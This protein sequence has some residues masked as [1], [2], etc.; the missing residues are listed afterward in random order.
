MH[1]YIDFPKLKREYYESMLKIIGSLSRLF[2]ESDVPYL[3]SR[4]AENLY[5]KSFGAKNKG[6]EDSSVDAVYNKAGIG[7][8]TFMGNGA[9]KIAEFNRDILQFASLRALEKAKKIAELRN[10]RIEF[11]KRAYGLN[12][13]QYHCIRREKGKMILCE[14]SMDLIDTAQ[15]KILQDT[16]KSLKFK[17]NK[18]SYIFNV[19]KSVLLKKFPKENIVAEFGVEI[20]EDPFKILGKT[21]EMHKKEVLETMKIK[22]QFVILP[23]YSM[24]K[25]EKIV[26]E[27]SGLNQWN[28]GGRKRDE[29]EVYIRVPHWIHEKFPG[30]FPKRDT[31]FKLRLPNGEFISAKICQDDDKALM[32]DPNKALGQW[33]L[34]DVLELKKGQLLN[35]KMLQEIGI[36]SVIIQKIGELEYSI[37]FREEGEFEDFEEEMS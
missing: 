21:L 17:D 5:C 36:D 3:D 12:E 32:S 8:K 10:K 6:R 25:D 34:R 14:S 33:I 29:D 11:T 37:D 20:L 18:N 9:Q 23:L 30:F 28:A 1:K 4:V 31:K 13:V 16:E 24:E 2:S 19:S 7:I 22:Y 26:P 35:Y 15:V 27:K